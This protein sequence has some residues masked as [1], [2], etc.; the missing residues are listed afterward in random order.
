[1]NTCARLESTS[2]RNRIQISEITAQ[3]LSEAGKENW[4]LNREDAVEAKGKGVMKTFWLKT[5]NHSGSQQSVTTQSYASGSDEASETSEMAETEQNEESEDQKEEKKTKALIDWNVETL[6]SLLKPVVVQRQKMSFRASGTSLMDRMAESIG[7]S[8]GI[9]VDEVA[10]TIQLPEFDPQNALLCKTDDDTTLSD[11]V[12]KELRMYVT[13]VASMYRNNAFHNFEHAT[14]VALAM[15][16]LLSRIVAPKMDSFSMD[17]VSEQDG[18]TME[19][20]KH[21]H[22]Y[23]ITSDPLTQFA[24]VFSALIHDGKFGLGRMLEHSICYQ[25]NCLT[26]LILFQW[27]TVELVMEFWP[28]KILI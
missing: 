25:V 24:V 2:L 20:R 18:A 26:W 22:T 10:E 3:L 9:V 17:Q 19:A 13:V 8:G 28:R 27:I 5:K 21:D 7:Q 11:T 23:G 12:M 16:K 6:A 4:F 15:R 1:M 14:N